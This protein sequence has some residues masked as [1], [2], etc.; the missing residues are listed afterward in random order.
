MPVV[1]NRTL[2][3]DAEIIEESAR[4]EAD[5]ITARREEA[6]RQLAIREL[7]QQQARAV[8][9]DTKTDLDRAIEELLEREVSLPE[10]DEAACRRYYDSNPDR[11]C[12]PVT[13]E[14]RH[15]LLKAAPD[16]PEER[17]TAEQQA[18][19][20]VSELQADPSCFAAL[21]TQY[22][23]CPSAGD[24]GHLGFINRGQTVPEFE[25]VVTRLAP[26]LATRPVESRYGFH[27]VEVLS[28]EGGEPLAFADVQ[29]LI[30]DY[31][32]EA[33]W[34][35]AVHQYIQVLIDNAEIKGVD[36][37]ENSSPLIQ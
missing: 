2:I 17:A 30:A 34:R 3:T 27:V 37:P 29:H 32:Q 8:G 5:G 20:L 7:L 18:E 16:N 25:Q 10:V 6:A 1:I 15:V 22:S 23:A 12:T 4:V 33:S 31:L 26:G 9:L 35:R 11:F 14:L 24:G 13:L 21:A 19:R 28:R 36:F